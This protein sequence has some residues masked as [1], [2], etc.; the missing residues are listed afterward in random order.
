MDVQAIIM[1]MRANQ[2]DYIRADLYNINVGHFR[3]GQA[4]S[5]SH[6]KSQTMYEYT[7]GGFLEQLYVIVDLRIRI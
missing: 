7:A 6:P 1:Q 3:L 2:R 4:A 5:N